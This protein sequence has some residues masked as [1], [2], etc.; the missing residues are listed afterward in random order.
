MSNK[1][2]TLIK[3]LKKFGYHISKPRTVD[4]VCNMKVEE[5]L[6]ISEYKDKTYSFCSDHCK[7]QFDA[8]PARYTDEP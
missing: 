8:A 4:V 3:K 1:I 2:Q 6:V 7:A 5:G